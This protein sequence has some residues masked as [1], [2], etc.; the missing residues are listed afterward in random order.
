[1][2]KQTSR[3]RLVVHVFLALYAIILAYIVGGLIAKYNVPVDLFFGLSFALLI[4]ATV[5]AIYEVG[6][7]NTLIF[8]VLTSAVGF[9]AEILG[10][11]SGF[12][13]GKYVYSDLLGPKIF[14]VPEVVPLIWFVI[15]YICFSQSFAGSSQKSRW[16]WLI[17]MIAL[18]S[19]GIMAWD[20]LV[21]PMFTSYGYWTWLANNPGPKL[22]GIPV[23]NFVGWFA[24]SFLM[25][26]LIFGA[27]H[28]RKEHFPIKRENSIDS[29]IAYVLLMIDGAVANATLGNYFA[30]V[31]GLLSMGGFFLISYMISAWLK[32]AKL[33]AR[34]KVV[35]ES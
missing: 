28:L 5:Q 29:R 31:I 30:I 6:I 7:T 25:L 16:S 13:F 18:T 3:G 26:F 32:G 1:V 2:N 20:L 12:P 15:V 4:F 17:P 33:D 8:F 22:N 24:V 14:G 19:F 21:D 10:T 23:T 27:F 11:A 34:K 9:L 35:Q